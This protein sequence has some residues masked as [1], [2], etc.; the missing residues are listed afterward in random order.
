MYGIFTYISP[1]CLI[2]VGKYTSHIRRIWESGNPL[3]QKPP[4]HLSDSL[5]V[6]GLEVITW[7]IIPFITKHFGKVPK[8]EESEN[9]YSSCMDTAYGY[10]SFPTPKI[11][12]L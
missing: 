4:K 9:L 2:N 8:M 12:L 1:K 5:T 10:G 6:P 3:R 11:V 7:R